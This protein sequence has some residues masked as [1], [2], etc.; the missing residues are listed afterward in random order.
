[1]R[2]DLVAQEQRQQGRQKRRKGR[3]G[4]RTFEESVMLTQPQRKR[5][6]AKGRRSRRQREAAARQPAYAEAAEPSAAR[7]RIRWGVLLRRL[8][9][10]LL[11]LGLIAAIVY[12][13]T[14][15]EFF[16]Y[17]ARV[18]G[19][20]YVDAAT[21]YQAAKVHEQN[22]FWIR[23]QQV[24]GRIAQLEGIKSVRVHCYLLPAEVKIEVEER[25]PV[26]MWRALK[27]QQ[28][29]WLDEEGMV[30]PYHGDPHSSD[31]IFVV[32]SG[33]LQAEVGSILAPEGVTSSV[34]KLDSAMPETRIYFYDDDRGLSFTQE[35][36]GA[37]WPVYVG[38]SEHLWRKIQVVQ[39]LTAHFIERSIQPQYVD[40]R[41]AEYPVYGQP[42]GETAAETESE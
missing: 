40:V 2:I 12:T 26:I 31:T 32:G 25:K 7:R 8:P 21:I 39:A 15:G 4:S 16:V 30:L 20:H 1:M 38:T 29:W 41:W 13:S 33:E 27:H 37:Q 17:E 22:I 24:A 42:V 36:N 11:L 18:V 9:A 3:R 14:D 23:P 35:L 19:A 28:D 34:L 10:A 5:Q 6:P